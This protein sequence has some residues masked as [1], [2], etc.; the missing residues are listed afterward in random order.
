LY[1]SADLYVFG[2]LQTTFFT[3]VGKYT[4]YKTILLEIFLTK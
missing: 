1:K 4:I 3:F 2:V